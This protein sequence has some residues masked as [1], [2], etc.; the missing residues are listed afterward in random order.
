[1]S[2]RFML[3][4]QGNL[5]LLKTLLDRGADVNSAGGDPGCGVKGS[6]IQD[7][8]YRGDSRIVQYLIER[9]AQIDMYGQ[10]LPNALQNAAA[11]GYISLVKLLLGAGAKLEGDGGHGTAL[12]S[13]IAGN[14]PEVILFLLE[15]GA[16]PNSVSEYRDQ[17]T[18]PLPN[19]LLHATIQG[20]LEI[21]KI[22]LEN[23]ADVNAPSK[24]WGS[25]ELPLQNAAGK[26]SIEILRTFL[27]HGAN[28]DAQTEDGWTAIHWAA[29]NGHHEALRLLIFD[30]HANTSLSLVNGSLA[31]HSAASHGY[32]KCIEVCLEAGLDVS[33]CNN[34]GRTALHWATEKGY[35]AAV[36]L[37]LER[38]VDVEVKEVGTNMTALDCARLKASEQSKN[39]SRL[40]LV[41]VLKAKEL[42]AMSLAVR[43]G[44][45]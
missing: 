19:P 45:K 12:H 40:N 28:V 25:S 44:V 35:Q 13:A 18:T 14:R 24:Y 22:V 32:P 37:L 2:D 3:Q 15:C 23:G 30:Y 20:H 41:K 38:G 9:D 42:G 1:M 26:G 6:A 17:K 34:V 4:H 29:R 7:A 16:D 10:G 43:L 27:E 33:A 31:L 21:V 36:E 5:D 8:A 39:T 11:K